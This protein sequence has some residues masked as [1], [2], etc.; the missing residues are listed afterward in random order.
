MRHF[1][2]KLWQPGI[3]SRHALGSW[4][5][6]GAR[7]DAALARERALQV[8]AKVVQRDPDWSEMPPT[9]ERE[10]LR[11]IERARRALLG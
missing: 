11:I 2:N 5:D 10:V 3:W 6:A 9:L 1:R 7:L 8:E 4:L